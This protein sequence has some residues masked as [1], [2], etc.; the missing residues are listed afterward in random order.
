MDAHILV[1]EDD[2]DALRKISYRLQYAGYRVTQ[3]ASGEAALHML[4]HDTFDVV[5][6]DISMGKVDGVAVLHAA[7]RCPAGP[8]VILLTGHGTLETCIEALRTGAF[9]YL[10]KPCS[11]EQMLA[12]VAGAVQRHTATQQLRD[13]AS[14][15]TGKPPT[16]TRPVPKPIPYTAP[17]TRS[18][19][20]VRSDSMVH[21]GALAIGQS[22]HE[23]WFRGQQVKVTPT[24]Y[25]L[26]CYLAERPAQMCACSAIVRYTH[27]IDAD[28]DDAYALVKS[29][30]QNLRKKL[31]TTYLV[32]GEG[33]CYML[34]TPEVHA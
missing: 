3:A 2:R 32:K 13:V 8:E 9:D 6:T 23:V 34:A 7:R 4:A 25:A 12:C 31:D 5:L 18:P 19:S 26:L 11:P 1:V 15:L 20:L 16:D 27:G 24:E 22:R 33:K 21:I 30:V 17:T 28:D 29:H 14:I 10:T